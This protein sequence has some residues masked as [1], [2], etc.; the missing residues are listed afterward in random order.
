MCW[1][2]SDTPVCLQVHGLVV[3]E[4]SLTGESD[5]VKKGA[6]PKLEPWVRSGTQVCEKGQQLGGPPPRDFGGIMLLH[7]LGNHWL[8]VAFARLSGVCLVVACQPVL[9]SRTLAHAPA[10]PQLC[11]HPMGRLLSCAGAPCISRD[12]V[13]TMLFVG[14]HFL[15]FRRGL[16]FLFPPIRSHFPRCAL[17]GRSS[18]LL[19]CLAKC[20]EHRMRRR[21]PRAAA[22]CW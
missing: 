14:R 16:L 17:G 18:M 22:A 2:N 12:V 7:R 15:R 21:S 3:D 11:P 6:L 1:A 8:Q 9:R 20:C 19:A 10:A 13:G 4:A 5:P